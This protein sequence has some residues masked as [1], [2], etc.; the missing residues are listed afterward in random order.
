M[1]FI[2]LQDVDNRAFVHLGMVM[3]IP[4]E[5]THQRLRW[6]PGAKKR[7]HIKES[8]AFAYIED[9]TS[10]GVSK[11]FHLANVLRRIRW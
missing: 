7:F 9:Y 1:D 8:N 11:L 3:A 2:F 4:K 6:S 5:R 10:W